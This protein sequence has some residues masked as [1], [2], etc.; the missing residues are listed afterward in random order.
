MYCYHD[1]FHHKQ[2]TYPLITNPLPITP[3]L[4]LDGEHK[5]DGECDHKW[6]T[7]RLGGAKTGYIR[8]LGG[9]WICEKLG[10]ISI[11]SIIWRS[12]GAA[13]TERKAP[14]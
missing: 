3:F 2:N 12:P 13:G 6:V 4:I 8:K 9:F 7:D 14:R 10:G 1:L 11:F 5:Y